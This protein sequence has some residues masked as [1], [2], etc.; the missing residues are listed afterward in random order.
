MGYGDWQLHLPTNPPQRLAD[1]GD[2]VY[3]A[4]QN[5][6]YFF[7]KN[8]NTTQ[9]LSRRD[10]LNDVGVAAVAYDSVTQQT[11]LAYRNTNIDILRPNGTVRNINDVLRKPIQGAKDVN[12][13]SVADS[14]AYLA[15]SF[16]IVVVDLVKLEITDTYSNIGP[17][18]AI[19]NVYSVAVAN[20]YV[21]AAPSAG[22][23]RGRSTSNLLDYR[24]WTV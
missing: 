12:D 5:A 6:F 2:R 1:A 24:N 7:D 10:G 13:V 16:G 14:K 8:L 17:A 4:A 3:V 23:L 11:V 18:G 22:L 9:V 21:Y 15:T 20:G 19:V